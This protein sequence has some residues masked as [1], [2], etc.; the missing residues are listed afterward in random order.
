MCRGHP[1]RH[2]AAHAPQRLAGS[3]LGEAARSALHVGA[4][5]RAAGAARLYQIKIDIELAG[6][7]AYRGKDRNR[8]RRC[9]LGAALRRSLDLLATKL[10]D[11]GAGIL[12]R[13]LRKLHQWSTNLDQVTLASKQV[14]DAAAP[15]RGHF[16][17]RLVGF[18]RNERLIGDDMVALVDVPGHDLGFF[19]T[20]AEIRQCEL[21][22]AVPR[23]TRAG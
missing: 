3:D 4:G 21:A 19:K 22:H 5:D 1:L 17:D 12:A 13:A 20:F 14:R 9:R 23:K 7:R 16:D 8:P 6:E 2:G 15:G 18:N 11:D 10:A